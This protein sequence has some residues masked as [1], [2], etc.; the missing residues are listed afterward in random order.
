MTDYSDGLVEYDCKKN[1][2]SWAEV[3]DIKGESP[4]LMEMESYLGNLNGR[5]NGTIL[6]LILRVLEQTI[7]QE[8]A[9]EM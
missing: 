8:V 6:R 9:Q 3:V 7:A 2:V 5:Q 1:L 4:R